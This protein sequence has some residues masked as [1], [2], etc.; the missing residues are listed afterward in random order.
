MDLIPGVFFFAKDRDGTGAY[1]VRKKITQFWRIAKIFY[2]TPI[3]IFQQNKS[4][5]SF[6]IQK[7]RQFIKFFIYFFAKTRFY[8]IRAINKSLS[9]RYFYRIA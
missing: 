4:Q 3:N 5:L 2:F 8:A 1:I 7:R 9:I 6:I